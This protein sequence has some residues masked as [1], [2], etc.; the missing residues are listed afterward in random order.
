MKV[1][2]TGKMT[3][4]VLSI[5]LASS[6]IVIFVSYWNS[7]NQVKAAAGIELTGCAN[8]TT[9][10]FNPGEIKRL[11]EGDQSL[12]DKIQ[13]ELSWTISQKPIFKNQY[14]LSLDGKVLAADASLQ[15]QG[16]HAGDDFYLDMEALD[17]IRTMRHSA[18]SDVYDFAE[19]KRITGYA[20]IFENNDPNG[21]LIALNAIDFDAGILT[22]RTWTMIRDSMLICLLLPIIAAAITIFFVRRTIAPLK[23]VNEEVRRVANGDFTAISGDI[24]S[25]DEAGQ[26]FSSFG[27]M[28]GDLSALAQGMMRTSS[29][30]GEASRELT[31]TAE[32][33]GESS[34][35]ISLAVDEVAAGAIQQVERAGSVIGLVEQAK[36][37]IA[38]GDA[39]ARTATAIAIESTEEARRC[40]SAIREAVE[41]LHSVTVSVKNAADSI[42]RLGARSDEIGGIVTVISQISYQTNLL[43]LNAGI[44][45]ARAGQQGRGFS[46]VAGE[47]RKLAEQSKASA[48]Q[49]SDMIADIQKETSLTVR[50][51]ENTLD[52]VELQADFMQ[53]GGEALAAILDQVVLTEQSVKEMQQI[54]ENIA[55]FIQEVIEATT[56]FAHFIQQTAAA[57]QQVSA[58]AHEQS[59][60]VDS[61][62]AQAASLEQ[63]SAGLLEKVHKFKV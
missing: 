29:Q 49:I 8:I 30:L 43:A 14:I 36:R 61:I 47:V 35:Q 39:K 54:S 22:E 41:H 34:R 42:H 10:L 57:S 4:I 31:S 13:N 53:Q 3:A 23:I 20:P 2:I 16:I 11:A 33:T 25:K 9:G 62:A 51:M 40:E 26:L 55:R 45:A 21:K 58:S 6:A 24:K 28:V 5:V 46:I 63:V 17:R 1:G 27:R 44:E 52:A 59:G 32:R 18:S 37:E 48:E 50:T 38:N 12:L 15:A 7:Y 60:Y 19:S 56:D